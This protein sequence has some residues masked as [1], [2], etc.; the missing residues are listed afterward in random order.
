MS[1]SDILGQN[2]II[3]QQFLPFL[4]G[5][6]TGPVGPTGP[7]GG[8]T[9]PTG[10]DGAPGSAVNTG[11][12]GPAGTSFSGGFANYYGVQS[13]VANMAAGQSFLFDGNF[14]YGTNTTPPVPTGGITSTTTLTNLAPLAP[15]GTVITLPSIGAYE[16]SFIAVVQ[17]TGGPATLG[18]QL[19]T[20]SAIN[21][22]MTLS[23][24]NVIL[25]M[26]TST[27]YE[28]SGSFIVSAPFINTKLSLVAA[29][30]NA[31]SLQLVPDSLKSLSI[32]QIS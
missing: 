4:S 3:L 30:L 11:A 16:V 29:F 6:E 23:Y 19:A 20:G 32:K 8:P 28:F 12:T 14:G 13:G 7:S 1:V 26:N 5:G 22:M 17:Q 27:L 24:T 18:V 25:N 21:T 10:A 31:S 9:G 15:A 2:G